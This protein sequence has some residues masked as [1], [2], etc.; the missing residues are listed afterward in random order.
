[1]KLNLFT[2]YLNIIGSLENI[3][4]ISF[5]FSLKVC[6]PS[7]LKWNIDSSVKVV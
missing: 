5:K 4:I 6:N 2:E 3:D 1:M 7:N